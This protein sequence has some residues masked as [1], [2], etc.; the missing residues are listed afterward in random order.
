MK[1]RMYVYYRVGNKN[2]SAETFTQALD[3]AIESFTQ[4][5]GY[6]PQYVVVRENEAHGETFPIPVVK[7][8]TNCPPS[9]FILYPVVERRCRKS[10]EG[11]RVSCQKLL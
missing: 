10:F 4:L 8:T 3:V 5:Q 7:V 9:H 1:G 11:I 6:K 2:H